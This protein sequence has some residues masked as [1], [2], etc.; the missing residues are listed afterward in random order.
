MFESVLRI[1]GMVSKTNFALVGLALLVGF[2]ILRR[3]DNLT[4]IPGPSE[5]PIQENPQI[6]ILKDTISGVQRFIGDTFKAPKIIP[7]E[8]L[9]RSARFQPLP[10]GSRFAINPF[11]GLRIS[12]PVGPRGSAKTEAFFGGAGLLQ[13]NQALVTQGTALFTQASNIVKDLQSQLKIL[14]TKSV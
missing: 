12:L 13:S 5:I 8:Q 1:A 2:L 3:S 14:E 11:T 10:K 4:D 7:K 9:T 6:Q